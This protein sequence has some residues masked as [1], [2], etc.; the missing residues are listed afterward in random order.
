MFK[1]HERKYLTAMSSLGISDFFFVFACLY[2]P[3]TFSVCHLPLSYELCLYIVVVNVCTVWICF[4]GPSEREI[5]TSRVIDRSLRPLF[6]SGFNSETQ[7]M[8]NMLAVDSVN[9]PDVLSINAASAALALSDIPWN[10]PVGAVRYK[11]IIS[12]ITKRLF[13]KFLAAYNNEKVTASPEHRQ[14]E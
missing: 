13:L 9:S 3:K 6:P 11:F 14:F 12:R 4:S 10:G 7:I 1:T 2:S 5:L 8:C